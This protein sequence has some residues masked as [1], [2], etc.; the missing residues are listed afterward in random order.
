MSIKRKTFFPKIS[1]FIIL[2]FSILIISTPLLEAKTVKAAE[3]SLKVELKRLNGTIKLTAK[4]SIK[5][6]DGG[7]TN[8]TTYTDYKDKFEYLTMNGEA[9]FCIE[10]WMQAKNGFTYTYGDLK[11][12]LD[13]NKELQN[14]IELVAYYGWY[15]SNKAMEDY[16][17]TQLLIWE[18]MSEYGLY[19][20][21]WQ[22]KPS[23]YD[24]KKKAII[25]NI[26]NSNKFPSFKGQTIDTKLGETTKLVDQNNVLYNYMKAQGYDPNTNIEKNGYILRYGIDNSN[27]YLEITPTEHAISG[28]SLT[29]NNIPKEYQG[30]NIAYVN[31][32]SQKVS[33]LSK[34]SSSNFFNLKLNLK[35][36][37]I[38]KLLKVDENNNPVKGV[39]FEASYNSDFS[40]DKWEMTTDINGIASKEL[41]ESNKTVYVREKSVPNYLVKSDEI[42]SIVL[43]ANESNEIKFVNKIVKG[44]VKIVKTDLENG[45]KLS[46]AKFEVK[47]KEDNK[48][49]EILETNE[50]GF[51]ES[52]L[53]NYGEY[54]IKEIKAP[55]NYKLDEK[56]FLIK[57]TENNQ[58]I[59]VDVPNEKANGTLEF[60][61]TDLSTGKP[62]SGATIEFY[63]KGND[64]PFL[65]AITDTNGKVSKEGAS[66][67]VDRITENGGITLSEGEYF[68]KETNAPKGYILNDEEHP[69]KIVAGEVT[70]DTLPNEKANGTLE[71]NK[72]T[73]SPSEKR[74]IKNNKKFEIVKTGSNFDINTLLYV[75]ISLV[76]VSMISA[77]VLRK[78]KIS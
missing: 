36:E 72:K 44:K 20:L 8:Y 53:L 30:T 58:V 74:E 63:Q 19:Q 24:V 27:Q 50:Q 38:L 1:R 21:N 25:K 6:P 49:I 75:G 51:A 5:R 39:I 17:S 31:P 11:T 18:L 7:N 33:P 28:T 77:F 54:I 10:P 22:I 45:F 15:A 42:K 65:T 16:A 47:N 41:Q 9:V 56:D 3:N 55:K 34:V 57:I 68:F 73:N 12:L 70:K 67:E 60:T 62:V 32:N 66:G 48:V 59:T 37:S 4:K 46:G 40:G 26:E 71:F 78:R 69:F 52:K 29:F 35:K 43:K 23:F 76:L 64:K 13:N 2:I 14:K 61:K